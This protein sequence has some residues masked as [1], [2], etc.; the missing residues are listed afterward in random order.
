MGKLPRPIGKPLRVVRA[1][2]KLLISAVV[3]FL[4][5]AI[6][7]GDLRVTTRV[8][9]AWNIGVGLYLGIVLYVIWFSDLA[10]IRRRA[11]MEDEGAALILFLTVL[12]AVASLAAIFAELGAVSD[13]KAS[14]IYAAHSIVTILLSW[15]FIHAIFA[16]H[17]ARAFYSEVKDGREGGLEFPKDEWPEYTD[18]IYFSFVIGMTFQVSDVQVTSKSVRRVV[19]C[20]GAV[21]FFYNVAVLALM[22]NIGGGF[23]K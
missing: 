10:H 1:H 2:S 7:P 21:A 5:F 14:G 9:I 22:V 3:G 15:T 13:A 17:Y 19:V 20:H 23:I 11:S 12:A 16:F 4:L 6:L 18:F 8:L